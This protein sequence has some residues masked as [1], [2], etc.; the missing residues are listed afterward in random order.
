MV[1]ISE[2]DDEKFDEVVLQSEL[3]VLVDFGADW[4]HPCKQLDP[5]VEEIAETWQGKLIVYKLDV[6]RNVNA[7]TAYGVMGVPSLVLF[8]HGE[9]VDRLTGLVPKKRIVEMVEP[10]LVT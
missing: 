5:I 2:I 10:H 7:T 9:P 3:P 4:C 8:V 1:D 6:D